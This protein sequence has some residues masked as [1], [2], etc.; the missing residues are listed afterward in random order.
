MLLIFNVVPRLV[1]LESISGMQILRSLYSSTESETL[2]VGLGICQL[3]SPQEI[4][5]H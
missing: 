4:L 1:S 5:V 2:G 3:T